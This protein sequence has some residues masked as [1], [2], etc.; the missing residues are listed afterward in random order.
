MDDSIA[1]VVAPGEP[2]R[3]PTFTGTSNDRT[4]ALLGGLLLAAEVL[5]GAKIG[6]A[7]V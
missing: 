3:L 4:V 5:V 7:H 6:R 1:V 2:V